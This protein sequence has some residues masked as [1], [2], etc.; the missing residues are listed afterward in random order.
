L[1]ALGGYTLEG[2]GKV[3]VKVMN[4]YFFSFNLQL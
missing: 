1:E 2:R 3:D 4:S